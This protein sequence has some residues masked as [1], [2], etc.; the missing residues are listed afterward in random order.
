MTRKSIICIFLYFLFYLCCIAVAVSGCAMFKDMPSVCGNAERSVLCD[1]S[2]K[3]DLRIEDIENILIIANS[4]SIGEGLYTKDEAL[5]VLKKLKSLL[6]TPISYADFAGA[7]G[8]SVSKYPGLIEV[9][10][11]YFN[12][13]CTIKQLIYAEDVKIFCDLLQRQINIL[14]GS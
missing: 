8:D 7:I 13:M 10:S 11:I 5:K 3:Y 2:A 4:V 12:E 14:S 1:I 6:D 9:I